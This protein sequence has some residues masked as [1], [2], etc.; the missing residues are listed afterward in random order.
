MNKY[1]VIGYLAE[2][3]TML[4]PPN[5]HIEGRHPNILPRAAAA[6]PHN[7]DSNYDENG[8]PINPIVMDKAP[9]PKK[10]KGIVKGFTA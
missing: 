10:A 3:E 5:H 4:A 9:K 2:G 1:I 7:L 6:N 8:K